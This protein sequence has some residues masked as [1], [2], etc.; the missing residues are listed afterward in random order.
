MINL[1]KDSLSITGVIAESIIA[2]KINTC[3]FRRMG[4]K[5]SKYMRKRQQNQVCK[6]LKY[7]MQFLVF[8]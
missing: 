3:C 1:L 2:L 6:I 8:I 4:R 7:C 5:I